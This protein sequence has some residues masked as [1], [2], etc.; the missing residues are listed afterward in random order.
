M[1]NFQKELQ[2]KYWIDEN[3]LKNLISLSKDCEK[4][5]F[6][7]DNVVESWLYYLDVDNNFHDE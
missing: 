2:E 6:D 5:W 4:Q 1:E 3:T 7:I